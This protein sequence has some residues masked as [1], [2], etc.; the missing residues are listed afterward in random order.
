MTGC[1]TVHLLRKQNRCCDFVSGS[2]GVCQNLLVA[3]LALNCCPFP[4]PPP[5]S[6]PPMIPMSQVQSCSTADLNGDFN[7]NN[8]VDVSDAFFVARTWAGQYSNNICLSGNFDGHNGFTLNDAMF[9]AKANTGLPGFH[10]PWSGLI[11]NPHQRR[12]NSH[13]YGNLRG[14]IWM[15]RKG[16]GS[17]DVY[18]SLSNSSVI[19]S[20][21]DRTPYTSASVKFSQPIVQVQ[22]R[23]TL[24]NGNQC[25]YS[26]V[27]FQ[28]GQNYVGIGDVL[29]PDTPMLINDMNGIAMTVDFNTDDVKLDYT[30]FEHSYIENSFESDE[31]V[32]FTDTPFMY[33][34]FNSSDFMYYVSLEYQEQMNYVQVNL[35][36]SI[37]VAELFSNIELLQAGITKLEFSNMIAIG[38]LSSK[39]VRGDLFRTAAYIRMVEGSYVEEELSFSTREVTIKNIDPIYPSPTPPSPHSPPSSPPVQPFLPPYT[40]YP[41]PPCAPAPIAS[42]S[43]P[44]LPYFLISPPPPLFP[45]IHPSPP[46]FGPLLS[47]L[48]FA[49][50]PPV[51]PFDNAPSYPSAPAPPPPPSPSSPPL[52]CP[53]SLPPFQTPIAPPPAMPPISI[54]ASASCSTRLPV[55]RTLSHNGD[56]GYYPSISNGTL[57][58]LFDSQVNSHIFAS[59]IVYPVGMIDV[60]HELIWSSESR[61]CDEVEVVWIGIDDLTVL[62][63]TV[64]LLL[65]CRNIYGNPVPCLVHDVRNPHGTVNMSTIGYVHQIQYRVHNHHFAESTPLSFEADVCN[66]QIVNVATPTS[67]SHASSFITDLHAFLLTS[68]R[69][70]SPY[71]QS[72]GLTGYNMF[73]NVIFKMSSLVLEYTVYIEY[74]PDVCNPIDAYADD[75]F[76]YSYMNHT[77]GNLVYHRSALTPTYIDANTCGGYVEFEILQTGTCITNASMLTTFNNGT[78]SYI[79]LAVSSDGNV[80][81]V[82][83]VKVTTVSYVD[84]ALPVLNDRSITNEKTYVRYTLLD[85][86]SNTTVI[87]SVTDQ[88]L[89]MSD[90]GIVLI[91]DGSSNILLEVSQ[92]PYNAS[93]LSIVA[94]D[95]VLNLINCTVTSYQTSRVYIMYGDI[96]VTL[97]YKTLVA[98]SDL[99]VVQ[100]VQEP[101]LHAVGVAPGLANLTMGNLAPMGMEVTSNSVNVVSVYAQTYAEFEVLHNGVFVAADMSPGANRASVMVVANFDDDTNTS[102]VPVSQITTH[103]YDALAQNPDGSIYVTPSAIVDG[104]SFLD[105]SYCGASVRVNVSTT[106][107]SIYTTAEFTESTVYHERGS[108]LLTLPI[109]LSSTTGACMS[110]VQQD[111]CHAFDASYAFNLQLSSNACLFNMSGNQMDAR[112]C[113]DVFDVDMS[114]T[115]LPGASHV[116]VNQTL[117]TLEV[118]FYINN[119][120]VSAPF[121]SETCIGRVE[122]TL[123]PRNILSEFE[124]ACIENCSISNG[125]VSIDSGPNVVVNVSIG[126]GWALLS[127]Q[128]HEFSQI[129]ISTDIEST[130]HYLTSTDY[131]DIHMT[132]DGTR[133]YN[134]LSLTLYDLYPVVLQGNRTL[135]F[136]SSYLDITIGV[137]VC[138]NIRPSKFGVIL[139]ATQSYVQ[140]LVVPEQTTGG[141]CYRLDMYSPVPVYRYELAIQS[142]HFNFSVEHTVNWLPCCGAGTYPTWNPEVGITIPFFTVASRHAAKITQIQHQHPIVHLV[143]IGRVCAPVLSAS[144]KSVEVAFIYA[145]GEQNTLDIPR[146]YTRDGVRYAY[147]ARYPFAEDEGMNV[148]QAVQSYDV[149]Y[150]TDDNGIFNYHDCLNANLFDENSQIFEVPFGNKYALCFQYLMHL[151]YMPARI[152][153]HTFPPVNTLKIKFYG[154]IGSHFSNNLI[155]IQNVKITM[156][157]NC[158]DSDVQYFGSVLQLD[159]SCHFTMKSIEIYVRYNLRMLRTTYVMKDTLA[160]SCVSGDPPSM[161]PPSMPPPSYPPMSPPPMHPPPSYPPSTPPTSPPPFI[162]LRLLQRHHHLFI[163]LRLRPCRRSCR[164][165][166]RHHRHQRHRLLHLL[167]SPLRCT[168]LCF[169]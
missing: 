166:H 125:F 90:F 42:P 76:T 68:I 94:D 95:N 129:N 45:P 89:Y 43:V 120:I 12:L 11:S 159:D 41:N 168:L 127:K 118:D 37:D 106:Q 1:T 69:A 161:P 135:V 122:Y 91:Q 31:S 107:F 133:L 84:T 53:P 50:P 64:T 116:R 151:T 38:A 163:P 105:I 72:N 93:D 66:D 2:H 156:Y 141:T 79:D 100:I 88:A 113:P 169:R 63:D 27:H 21:P 47:E 6:S 126:N 58:K 48:P 16:F 81:A 36:A 134:A 71:E 24:S 75:A 98:S 140:P 165:I 154:G 86:Y 78:V 44:P 123:R 3:L 137:N 136:S 13:A 111:G 70:C 40:P 114:M 104:C 109:K 56:A 32:R 164:L 35:D 158:S 139:N 119:A 144:D 148:A 73:S 52:P 145:E 30:D 14:G 157:D 49:P 26:C 97:R 152:E 99:N 142:P 7:G 54:S 155:D 132:Y 62:S 9:A 143:T 82:P 74:A 160:Y 61:T 153:C 20:S 4:P 55:D 19:F 102:I 103:T 117:S 39:I 96:D 147:S 22:V 87:H 77:T 65:L 51:A 128:I 121:V 28:P 92:P 67:L 83:V 59:P 108:G 29:T 46:P 146:E 23:A 8:I 57:V 150:D 17:F 33:V 25:S 138:G 85:V 149:P 167:P 10:Y 112:D 130:V 34:T 18:I 115:G 5:P 110:T 131:L 80:T 60:P 15:K 124:I 101:Y 162:L